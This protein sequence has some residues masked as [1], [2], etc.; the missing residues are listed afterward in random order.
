VGDGCSISDCPRRES[1]QVFEAFYGSAG[2]SVELELLLP[3]SPPI[4]VWWNDETS[5]P[6]EKYFDFDR[7]ENSKSLNIYSQIN[8][9]H[10]CSQP[11]PKE[12]EAYKRPNNG[13][14]LT[15]ETCF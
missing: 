1:Y 4:D 6:A 10:Y 14:L 2:H 9:K 7:M 5:F 11:Y 3:N 12:N 8:Q 15:G 13:N